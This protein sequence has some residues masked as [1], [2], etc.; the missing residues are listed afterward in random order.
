MPLV[1]VAGVKPWGYPP[2]RPSPARGEGED[3]AGRDRA[4]Y[5]DQSSQLLVTSP[6]AEEVDPWSGSGGGL[7]RLR[8]A[9]GPRS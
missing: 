3:A 1:E 7:R 8:S 2:P 6:L 4:Y 9:C 5:Y